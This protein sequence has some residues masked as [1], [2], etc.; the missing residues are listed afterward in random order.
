MLSIDEINN[1][2]KELKNAGV[3]V[4]EISDGYHTIGDY[5]DMR[6]FWF[7]ATLNSNPNISWKARK[8]FD[9]ENDPMFGGDFIAGIMTP[10]GIATQHLKM[11]YWDDLH[12][13]ELDRAPKYEGYTEEDVKIRIKSIKR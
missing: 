7:I 1:A 2:I 13:K 10:E 3:S 4:N 6:N 12:V 9:E 8:H 11:K 5:K